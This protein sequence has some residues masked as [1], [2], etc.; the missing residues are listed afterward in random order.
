MAKS[1]LSQADLYYI[2]RFADETPANLEEIVAALGQKDSPKLRAEVEKVRLEAI[3][4]RA[5][6]QAK[7]ELVVKSDSGRR[8]V[9]SMSAAAS[10]R[11]P[12]A[13]GKGVSRSLKNSIHVIEPDKR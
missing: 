8:E 9:V 6:Q 11:E 13:T 3:Q 4:T 5:A 12:P 10:M 1:L 2:S 7:G